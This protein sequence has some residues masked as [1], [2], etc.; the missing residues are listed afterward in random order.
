[1]EANELENVMEAILFASGEP[2]TIERL[3]EIL[4]VGTE[5]I[6]TA[7]KSLSDAYS[8]SRRGI[9]LVRM[10]NKLQLCSAPEYADTVRLA[11]E[12]R[13][14]PQL[15]QTAM[16]V[17]SIV[18]YFQPVTRAYIEQIRGVDSGYTVNLLTERG[19]IEP[20][21]RLNAP[22]R[23]MLYKTTDIF[24]RTFGITD[25]SE[26]P[27]LPENENIPTETAETQE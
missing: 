3:A 10:E 19:L 20:A 5:E 23:P 9:R 17:L 22:G 12:T 7:A 13:K 4:L 11:L 15:S 16:E 6:E 25:L 8:F 26:L 24:L 14:Q 21:G 2:V 18:A 27:E 1:M